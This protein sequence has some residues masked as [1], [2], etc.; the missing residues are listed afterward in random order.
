[1]DPQKIGKFICSLRKKNGM[2]QNELASKL[3]VT[4]QAVSKWENGRGIPDIEI[5]KQ[6]S[7]LFHVDLETILNGEEKKKKKLDKKVFLFLGLGILVC[8]VFVFY[9]FFQNDKSFSFSDV[10]SSNESFSIKGVAAYSDEKSSIFISDIVY[11]DEENTHEEYVSIEC[12]LYETDGNVERKI[13]ESGI[14]QSDKVQS[15]NEFLKQIEFHIDS[16]EIS[17]A[18]LSE[19]NLYLAIH[20]LNQEG[21]TETYIVPIELTSCSVH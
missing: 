9:F 6:I 16:F 18:N 19:S 17:C 15:L 11:L 7:E 21:K 14:I 10:V 5:L 3:M 8:F 13:G 20:A 2:T 12:L 4:S 1:M